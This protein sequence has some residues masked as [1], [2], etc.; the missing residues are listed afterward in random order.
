MQNPRFFQ[1]ARQFHASVD[2]ARAQ[3]RMDYVLII[4]S[5][6]DDRLSIIL[7]N[8]NVSVIFRQTWDRSVPVGKELI[9]EC[10]AHLRQLFEFVELYDGNDACS[11]QILVSLQNLSQ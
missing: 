5:E 3:R 6:N 10:L 7:T 8:A 4:G 11:S 1:I 9:K 2:A